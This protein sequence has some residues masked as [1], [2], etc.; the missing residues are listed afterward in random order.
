MN[1]IQFNFIQFFFLLLIAFQ[2]S[3]SRIYIVFKSWNLIEIKIFA[4]ILQT[5]ICINHLIIYKL[6]FVVVVNVCL[7]NQFIKH[8][9]QNAI[10]TVFVDAHNKM[11]VLV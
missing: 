6:I 5:R 8:F 1:Q 10:H 3:S 2:F 11:C 9:K 4:K 7:K